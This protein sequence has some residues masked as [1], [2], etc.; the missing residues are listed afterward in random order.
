MDAFRVP[1]YVEKHRVEVEVWTASGT[2]LA[3]W[4]ALAPAAADH[5]GPESLVE[6]LNAGD[7]VF[8]LEGAGPEGGVLLVNPFDV[9]RVSAAADTPAGLVRRACFGPPREERVRLLFRSGAELEGLVR[10]ELPP[11][12][13]RI[14]DF[15][16]GAEEFF[17]LDTP[18]GVWIVH[19]RLVVTT[20]L[21]QDS[22]R[23]GEPQLT[24]IEGGDR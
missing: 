11:G 21:Y 9:E 23:P 3:G 10:F 19:K 6:R 13:N 5:D 12:L 15:L 2:V 24:V 8:P 16:N 4:I 22:P 7:R 20:R 18:K 14:S 17:A 1:E